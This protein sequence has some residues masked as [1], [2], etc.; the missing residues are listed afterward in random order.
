MMEIIF[1]NRIMV[2]INIKQII[3]SMCDILSISIGGEICMKKKEQLQQLQNMIRKAKS[4]LEEY[5]HEYGLDEG[6]YKIRNKIDMLN[7]VYEKLRNES[8]W[9]GKS[10]DFTLASGITLILLSSIF[11][12]T[13]EELKYLNLF[14][15]GIILIIIAIPFIYLRAKLYGIRYD[16]SFK[17]KDDEDDEDD[18]LK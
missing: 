14:A 13:A 9:D 11:Y 10:A 7:E 18:E 15:F 17:R 8:K 2:N 6:Y 1:V 3:L 4:E 5:Y 12:L 16:F